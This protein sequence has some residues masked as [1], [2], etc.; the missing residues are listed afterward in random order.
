M[1]GA[2]SRRTSGARGRARCARELTALRQTLASA[3]ADS[4]AEWPSLLAAIDEHLSSIGSAFRELE[5]PPAD[6][7]EEAPIAEPAAWL[8]KIAAA[9]A[10]HARR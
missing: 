8:E 4:E 10:E 5:E 7:G 1:P 9:L 3:V 2:A 6:R